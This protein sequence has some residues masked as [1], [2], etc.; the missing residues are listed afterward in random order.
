MDALAVAQELV[1]TNIG[2]E[3][4]AIQ[5][6]RREEEERKKKEAEEA[7]RKAAEEAATKAPAPT[8]TPASTQPKF[9][10]DIKQGIAEAIWVWGSST[11]GWGTGNTRKSRI[12]SKFGSGTGKQVQD[13]IDYTVSTKGA[14]KSWSSLKNYFY[15]SFDTGGYTGDWSGNK[16]KMAMLHKKELVLNA[17]D[18]ENMLTAIKLLRHFT[19]D[20]MSK[21]NEITKKSLLKNNTSSNNYSHIMEETITSMTAAISTSLNKLISSLEPNSTGL[22]NLTKEEKSDIINIEINA[23]FPNAN[24]ADE[25]E[26]A[27]LHLTN[28]ATQRAH[29]TKK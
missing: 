28:I 9:T 14:K 24:S 19:D 3:A 13:Y 7:A 18:T 1:A 20:Y 6:E 21:S 29:S 27:F 22:Q 12:D 26:K 4:D 2:E 8:P 23:D 5:T 15:S 25:I 11:S 16:G 17:K 10:S